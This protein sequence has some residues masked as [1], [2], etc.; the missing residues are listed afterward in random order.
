MFVAGESSGVWGG[1]PGGR[2]TKSRKRATKTRPVVAVW[3][4]RKRGKIY[5]G[6]CGERDPA[7]LLTGHGGAI[8]SL[9][10]PENPSEEAYVAVCCRWS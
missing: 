9:Y 10:T 5:P 3:D 8:R 4:G 7:R 6:Y 1:G 2:G